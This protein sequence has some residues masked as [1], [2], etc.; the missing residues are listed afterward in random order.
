MFFCRTLR[1]FLLVANYPEPSSHS[2]HTYCTG[3]IVISTDIVFLLSLSWLPTC[4]RSADLKIPLNASSYTRSTRNGQLV[5][6][7]QGPTLKI[8]YSYPPSIASGRADYVSLL[9]AGWTSGSQ[10]WWI[11]DMG[12][13]C[14]EF[15]VIPS[16][17]YFQ[18]QIMSNASGIYSLSLNHTHDISA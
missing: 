12:M 5:W 11:S 17:A 2:S 9:W 14:G 10:A 7:D 4:W 16:F 8:N 3:T 1:T 13:V 18:P 6:P 15:C